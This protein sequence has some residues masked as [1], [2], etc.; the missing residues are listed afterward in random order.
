MSTIT[1]AP[2]IERSTPPDD[3]GRPISQL[4]RRG[5]LAVWDA[6]ALPMAALAWLVASAVAEGGGAALSRALI[7]CL[8]LG[9]ASSSPTRPAA[10]GAR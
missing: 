5:V 8:T 9:V 6:A 2:S 7:V 10:T 1:P 3:G 4:S